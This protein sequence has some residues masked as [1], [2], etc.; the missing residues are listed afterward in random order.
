MKSIKVR[1]ENSSAANAIVNIMNGFRDCDID[2]VHGRYIIDAKSILGVLSMGLPCEVDFILNSDNPQ[3]QQEFEWGLK[4]ML[5]IDE[6]AQYFNIGKNKL[7]ELTKDPGCTFVVYVG[8]KC[9][10]KRI[11]FEQYLDNIVYL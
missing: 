8:K 11:G 7:R 1:I 9:L 6:A 5:T 2:C 4:Y 3:R 10:I